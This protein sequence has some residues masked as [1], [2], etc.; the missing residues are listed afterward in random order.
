MTFK[1]FKSKLKNKIWRNIR[2]YFYEQRIA[3]G[4]VVQNINFDTVK[5]QKKAVICY[6]TTS[7]FADWDT[8]NIGRT[9][10]F[11]ILAITKNLIGLGY[12]ID[13]IGCN[14]L[15]ALDQLGNKKYD[16][17]F[18]F[19][20]THYRLTKLHPNAIS[21]LYMTEHHPD[22]AD[23]AEKKRLAYFYERHHKN[24]R[25]V[26][27]GNFYKPHHF[28]ISY[29]HVITMSEVEPFLSEYAK[30]IPIFPTG[31]INPKFNPGSKNQALAKKEF[32]WLG[33]FGAIHKGLDILLDVFSQREDIVLH[34]AGLSEEDR[35]LLQPAKRKNI[36]DHGFVDIKS[37]SFLNLVQKC[38]FV[39]LLSCSEGFSTA[40]TT[41][42]LHG[43][44]PVV[45]KDT[46]FN[47]MGDNGFLLEDFKVSFVNNALTDLSN[48]SEDYLE[49]LSQQVIAFAHENLTIHAFDRKIN[50]VLETLLNP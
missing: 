12:R 50:N 28:T 29:N 6:L 20:E 37:D 2:E 3:D 4:A 5:P 1:T 10:P 19:G 11:E 47:R 48:L 44:I 24:A 21:V 14:D 35:N 23:V 22:F 13:V 27:S 25:I 45:N 49:T 32:L 30:P 33:S 41:G 26:R 39:I 46:G 16:L 15:R 38:A 18:G 9:Q 8:T 17:V 31:V 42:M 40:V 36:I 7:F 43:L 34:I